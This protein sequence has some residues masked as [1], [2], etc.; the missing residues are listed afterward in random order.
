MRGV[1]IGSGGSTITHLRTT[2]KCKIQ[3]SDGL[4]ADTVVKMEGRLQNI[5]TVCEW[6][7]NERE[8]SRVP[9]GSSTKKRESI[10][11]DNDQ[12]GSENGMIKE[13]HSNSNGNG[14]LSSEGNGQFSSES[15]NIKQSSN[16]NGQ[17]SSESGNIKQSSS[18][19]NGQLSSESGHIKQSSSSGNG[20]S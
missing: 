12:V 19:G 9:N 8:S 2:N 20:Q 7:I 13:S 18:S 6:I 10:G 17:L 11:N 4:P 3:L 15:G 5:Q 16:G 1:I 14:H